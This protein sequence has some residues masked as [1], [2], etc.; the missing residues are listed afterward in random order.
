VVEQV[1]DRIKRQGHDLVPRNQSVDVYVDASFTGNWD[2]NTARSRHGHVI[3]YA[4]CSVIWASNLQREIAL[5]TSEAEYLA[6]LSA[7]C[8]ILATTTTHGVD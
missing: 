6:I 5:S 4:S 1:P 3:L 2:P 8:N 7:T